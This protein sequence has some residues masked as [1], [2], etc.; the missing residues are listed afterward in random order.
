MSAI[1]G[2]ETGE[3]LRILFRDRWLC[4]IDKP[5]GLMV[6]KT[7]LGDD[8]IFALQRL[9]DQLGQRVWPLHRLDRATSGVLLFALDAETATAMG[10]QIMAHQLDKRY[11]AVVRGFTDP[12][13]CIDHPLATGDH[14]PDQ[15]ALT[16]YRRLATMELAEPV[17]RYPV[18]RYSLV[19]AQ[20][21]SGRTHQIRRHF[22]HIFHPLIGDTTYGEGRHNRLFRRL[23]ACHRLLLHAVELKLVHPW[24]QQDLAV[25]APTEGDFRHIESIFLRH[26]LR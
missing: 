16:R 3:A 1:A 20:P 22:K 14:R 11:L 8:Q 26:S 25:R 5:C 12:S 7:A 23:F 10:Q 13:G 21:E 9:R 6:H 15:P 19:E 24:T 2:P 17:G 4:A 18:A